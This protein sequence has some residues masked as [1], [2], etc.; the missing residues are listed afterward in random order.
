MILSDACIIKTGKY[1]YIKFEQGFTFICKD[2]KEIKE[3]IL[4]DSF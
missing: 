3:N 1:P 4:Y 2:S